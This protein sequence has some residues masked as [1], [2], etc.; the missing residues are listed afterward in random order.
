MK[1]ALR[2]LVFFQVVIYKPRFVSCPKAASWWVCYGKGFIY[3]VV[4]LPGICYLRT[5]STELIQQQD[6]AMRLT[7]SYYY[8][9]SQPTRSDR[10]L[11][12]EHAGGWLLQPKSSTEK[13]YHAV[14]WAD[15]ITVGE[16]LS[17]QYL[18]IFVAKFESWV[19]C[20][21]FSGGMCW[22]LACLVLPWAVQAAT[23]VDSGVAWKESTANGCHWGAS[24]NPRVDYSIVIS[25]VEG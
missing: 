23:P 14:P 3:I 17:F 24:P 7:W 19:I 20:A 5:T 13:L 8:S 18:F 22:V 25:E 4:F 12:T 1:L 9:C 21:G 15:D 10:Q 16:Q 2:R 6:P 11:W